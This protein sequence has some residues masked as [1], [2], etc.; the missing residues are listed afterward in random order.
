[1]CCPGTGGGVLISGL[2]S[3]NFIGITIW[4]IIPGTMGTASDSQMTCMSLLVQ[5]W[6]FSVFL[7]TI[8][9]TA[10]KYA[11]YPTNYGNE[12]SGEC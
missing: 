3:E 8:V 6:E 2:V 12:L 5:C 1:M 4:S 10:N 11:R 9:L 7:G